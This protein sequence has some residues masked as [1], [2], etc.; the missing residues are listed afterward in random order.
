[1]DWNWECEFNISPSENN[2]IYVCVHTILEV[3]VAITSQSWFNETFN[4][5]TEVNE[6]C[7]VVRL[8]SSMLCLWLPMSATVYVEF[9]DFFCS[10]WQ[11]KTNFSNK[12]LKKSKNQYRAAVIFVYTCIFLSVWSDITYRHGSF[13][14]F[15]SWYSSQS[16]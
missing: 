16:I 13:S 8:K 4:G 15:E 5:K 1:M 14:K 12:F 11:Q 7:I 3:N 6:L 2:E 10:I 9:K